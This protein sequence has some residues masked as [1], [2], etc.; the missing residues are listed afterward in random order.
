[1][2]EPDLNLFLNDKINLGDNFEK[3]GEE[4]EEKNLK[5]FV[6]KGNIYINFI[7]LFFRF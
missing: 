4:E 6:N 3:E 1:M 5:K 7:Y 2:S